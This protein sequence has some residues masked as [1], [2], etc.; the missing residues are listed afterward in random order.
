MPSPNGDFFDR[1]GNPIEM[2]VWSNL[3]RNRDYRTVR[4]DRLGDV[5]V[6]TIWL[7]MNHAFDDNVLIFETMIFDGERDGE[8]WRWTTEAEALAGHQAIMDEIAGRG[9]LP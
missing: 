5:L 9:E 8:Q 6:S 3:H 7:G 1:A 4:Q 2:E